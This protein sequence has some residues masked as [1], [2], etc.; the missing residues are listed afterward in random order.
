M[1]ILASGYYRATMATGEDEIFSTQAEAEKWVEKV[2]FTFCLPD[3]AYEI[4]EVKEWI[5]KT[6]KG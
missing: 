4:R 2:R 3:M 1:K 6:H 5:V